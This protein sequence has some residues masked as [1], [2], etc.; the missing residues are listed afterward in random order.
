[1]PIHIA[2]PISKAFPA[3]VISLNLASV[4]VGSLPI[5]EGASKSSITILVMLG[6]LLKH[7]PIPVIPSSVSTNTKG[8]CLS[9]TK[10]FIEVI[11]IRLP[12]RN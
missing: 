1:M 11:F 7:S 4:F 12:Y 5:I 10:H 6:C 3:L 8:N 2:P 9:K